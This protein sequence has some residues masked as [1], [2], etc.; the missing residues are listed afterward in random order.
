MLSV[1]FCFSR[2]GGCDSDGRRGRRKPTSRLRIAAGLFLG[3]NL[4]HKIGMVCT[5]TRCGEIDK[6]LGMGEFVGAL[7]FTTSKPLVMDK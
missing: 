2:S 1:D 7:A 4:D 3:M 5:T 6:F